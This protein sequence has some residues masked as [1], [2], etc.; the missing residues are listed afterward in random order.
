MISLT[1]EEK[2]HDNK[3]KVSYI[4]KKNLIIMIRQSRVL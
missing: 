4:C 3:Q 2:V 1:T